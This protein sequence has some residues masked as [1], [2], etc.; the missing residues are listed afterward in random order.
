M[1]KKPLKICSVNTGGTTVLGYGKSR[2]LAKRAAWLKHYRLMSAYRII[3]KAVTGTLFG[4][5]VEPALL[6]QLKTPL[7]ESYNIRA[8]MKDARQAFIATW[9]PGITQQA[10]QCGKSSTVCAILSYLRALVRMT[11]ISS[12]FS[13]S[14]ENIQHEITRLYGD[15][16]AYDLKKISHQ[17]DTT[18][19][20]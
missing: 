16:A 17:P 14:V 2:R 5:H 12:D 4:Q 1:R 11:L 20:T 13:L 10:R 18:I 19:T 3:L 8:F 7:S 15:K 9:I 6:K